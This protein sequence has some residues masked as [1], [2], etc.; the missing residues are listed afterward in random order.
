MMRPRWQ[1][2]L[3]DLRG[4]LGRSALVIAS[5]AIG[6]FA[7]GVIATL[8]VVIRQDMRG[9]YTATQPANIRLRTS[10][11]DEDMVAS[12]RKV[13]GIKDAQG[14][15]LL[16][17]RLQKNPE[18][19][20]T[21][22]LN[23]QQDF[24]NS[25]I[26]KLSLE[27]GTLN[28]SKRQILI[29]RYKLPDL[30]AEIGDLVVIETQ[31]GQ[32]RQLELVGIVSDQTN[33]AFSGGGGFFLS[34]VQGYVDSD[35]LEWLGLPL[36]DWYDTLYFTV[37]GDGLDENQIQ[38]VADRVR[39]ELE[40]RDVTVTSL[41]TRRTDD[42]PN[43]PY[44]NAISGVLLLLG[45]FI[46]F[47]STFLITNTLQA[48]LQQ[49]VE[50]IGI[51]K[52]VGAR[53]TQIIVIY[54]MLILAFGV[55]AFLLAAPLTS[56][57]SFQLM[58]FLV[59]QLNFNLLGFR[60]VPVVVIAQALIAII[61]P[62]LAAFMPIW[63]G[64]RLSVQEALSGVRQGATKSRQAGRQGILRFKLVSRPLLISLRNTFRSKG[65]MAL[66]LVT[67]SL[68]GA[69][70]ISTFNVQ[71]SMANYIE[72]ISQYFI[73]DLNLTLAYPYRVEKI[74]DLL[75]PLDEIS[76]VEGWMTAR[77]E[78]LLQDGSTGEAVQLLAPPGGS[79]LVEPRLLVGRWLLPGDQNAIVLN[80]LFRSTYPDLQVGDTL[81]LQ[82]NGDET[83]WTVV[84]FFQFAGRSVG[85]MAYTNA[86]YLSQLVGLPG[87]AVLFRLVADRPDLTI[88]QQEA[89]GVKVQNLLEGRGIQ[90]AEVE[91]G[92]SV[93]QTAADGFTILTAFLLFMAVLAAV[94]GSIGLAGTMSI[95]VME[96]TR[97]IGIM[98]AIG[99][100]NGILMMM[101]IIEGYLIGIIS[102]ALGSLLAFP[103]T[104]LMSN[105]I[106]LALFEAS[107]SI[108][109]TPT[110]FL[111]WFVVVS[112]LSIGASVLPARKAANLTIREVLAYE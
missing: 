55:A 19:W 72:Q 32:I 44:V 51:M 84:G 75:S 13:A 40:N 94:V 96:R 7:F 91:A 111:I 68:G 101:V 28:P 56:W 50:Q 95:N 107:T 10:L 30:N 26:S 98:R 9:G 102:W 70:F 25:S 39:D 88:S 49:Q 27:E 79:Q 104:N 48:L 33:G 24:E 11:I 100:S 65:R 47:L 85:Y 92:L 76:H 64:S 82:V 16:S 1:K 37:E 87:Q 34:P 5:I 90:I 18:E 81:R 14:A 78:I 63:R 66:T 71:L 99:S 106:S 105:S 52:T 22:E 35:T 38:V 67:L 54:M 3:A 41:A 46:A 29:E 93:S 80:E 77:S 59:Y 89:L 23:S 58:D 2:V 60:I 69:L 108:T 45:L 17:L 36:P 83:D 12:I 8:Y 21:I 4:N 53:R 74:E 20:I 62:Q 6:L 31:A 42:H 97:E 110:G 43:S 61:V 103:I 112:L 86:E 15:R 109:Y 73:G 57:V